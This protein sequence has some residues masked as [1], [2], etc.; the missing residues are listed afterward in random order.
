VCGAAVAGKIEEPTGATVPPTAALSNAEILAAGY[1]PPRQFTG[2]GLFV[3]A[4]VNRAGSLA[5]FWRT[6]NMTDKKGAA[7]K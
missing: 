2:R 7:T 1:L 5:P 3:A 4:D 6:K